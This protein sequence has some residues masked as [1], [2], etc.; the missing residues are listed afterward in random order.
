MSFEAMMMGLN[1]QREKSLKNVEKRVL[2]LA[3]LILKARNYR[4][5]GGRYMF[6]FGLPY[7]DIFELRIWDV[8]TGKTVF[9]SCILDPPFLP[10]TSTSCYF[11]LK[12]IKES[13]TAAIKLI[14]DS[15]EAFKKYIIN[16]PKP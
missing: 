12:E 16:Q 8:E 13:E 15:T 10:M 11:E 1:A 6:Q 5:R 4:K 2:K 3:G 9:D 14:M 7:Y